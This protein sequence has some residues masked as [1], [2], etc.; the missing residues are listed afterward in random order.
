MA[1]NINLVIEVDDRKFE[2][3][4]TQEM[5]AA[6]KEIL[7]IRVEARDKYRN[8]NYLGF[9]YRKAL[10]NNRETL[11]QA[12][13]KANPFLENNSHSSLL[14][15]NLLSNE[16]QRMTVDSAITDQAYRAN[17]D[18][19]YCNYVPR[20]F[21]PQFFKPHPKPDIVSPVEK[22]SQAGA[23]AEKAQPSQISARRRNL[24]RSPYGIGVKKNC[25][26]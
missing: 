10:S 14:L 5:L 4:I 20:Y 21:F 12:A 9:S 23:E 3:V 6:A 11:K 24:P 2:C 15:V 18:E 16:T 25:Q 7:R 13:K 26:G 8:W 1:D 19:R 17:R 22:T